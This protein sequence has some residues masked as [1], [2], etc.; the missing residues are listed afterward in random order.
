VGELSELPY[1]FLLTQPQIRTA[2]SRIIAQ[3]KTLVVIFARGAHDRLN[4]VVPHAETSYYQMRPA[5]AIPQNQ[6]STW[7]DSSGSS[8]RSRHLNRSSIRGISRSFMPP[9]LPI[10]PGLTLGAQKLELVFPGARLQTAHF[11]NLI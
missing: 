11:S 4:I 10:R 5:I 7:T 9:D 8:L 1:F 6:V 2:T 3:G